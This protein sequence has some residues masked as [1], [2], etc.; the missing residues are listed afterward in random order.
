[1][2][3]VVENSTGMRSEVCLGKMPDTLNG[4]LQA[5]IVHN[6]FDWKIDSKLLR[7]FLSGSE[8]QLN[9]AVFRNQECEY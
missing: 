9:S 1:M 8:E 7:F 6:V 3:W 2:P 5:V 4:K